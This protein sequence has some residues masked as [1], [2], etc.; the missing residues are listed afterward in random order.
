MKFLADLY[1]KGMEAL[2]FGETRM[3]ATSQTLPIPPG[4][5]AMGWPPRLM[6][7]RADPRFAAVY[8]LAQSCRYEAVHAHQV[9]R[10]AL[11]IFHQ[12]AALHRRDPRLRYWLVCASLLHDIGYVEGKAGHH[13]TALRRICSSTLL[14]WS[15][16]RRGIVGSIARYHRK[17]LPCESHDHFAALAPADR[18]S[19]EVLAG[20]LRLADGLDRGHRCLVRDLRL[21]FR[22][23]RIALYCRTAGC[24]DWLDRSARSKTDLLER[25]AERPVEIEW[26]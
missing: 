19:V 17:A 1:D 23:R 15:D 20:I 25:V 18:R 8:R 14:D 24:P 12:T 9:A 22:P 7:L 3:E 5:A 11:R 21:D 13:K 6:R 10:L 4:S 26:D 16:R 2:T